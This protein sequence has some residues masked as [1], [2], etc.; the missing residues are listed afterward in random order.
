MCS[1]RLNWPMIISG[2]PDGACEE[3]A[4]LLGLNGD[5]FGA[6]MLAEP[7]DQP[8]RVSCPPGCIS[9]PSNYQRKCGYRVA[10]WVLHMG[11]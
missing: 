11:L 9:S 10:K 1:M 5:G 2:A 3:D 8:S 4:D 6:A 7:A